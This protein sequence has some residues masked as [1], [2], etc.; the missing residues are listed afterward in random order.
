[1][2]VLL[3]CLLLGMGLTFTL[4]TGGKFSSDSSLSDVLLELG[5]HKPLHY[6]EK[7]S[8][9]TLLRQGY[10]I[11]TEGKTIGPDGKMSKLQ[12]KHFKCTH[13]HNLVQED[14]DLRVSDP[15]ARLKYADQNNIPFLQGTTFYGMVNRETFYND[16]YQV[17]YGSLVT[18][19]RDTLLNAVYL[20]TVQCSQGRALDEWE[21]EAVMAYLNS[22]S[23]KL[24]DLRL[25]SGDIAKL[26]RYKKGGDNTDLIAWLKTFYLQK[27]PA[28]FVDPK[29]HEKGEEQKGDAVKGKCFTNTLVCIA[30]IMKG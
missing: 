21:T 15:E 8:D 10:E 16:D 19:A 2:K 4:E 26:N 17:K 13:C 5:E 14:P 7:K 25:S 23:F 11:I 22:L 30:T 6:S 24:S 3:I 28:K 27:S 9:T 1:M 12:S 29:F 18:P 20:C